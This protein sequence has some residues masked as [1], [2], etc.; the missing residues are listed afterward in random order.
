MADAKGTVHYLGQGYK[1]LDFMWP[2]A[3][4]AK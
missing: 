1:P 4:Q 3:F 2:I